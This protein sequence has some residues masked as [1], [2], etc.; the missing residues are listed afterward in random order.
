VLPSCC[1]LTWSF[2]AHKVHNYN[3]RKQ[4]PTYM[5]TVWKG[6]LN[7][8]QPSNQPTWQRPWLHKDIASVHI[9]ET[10]SLAVKE[11]W[12]RNC[13]PNKWLTLHQFDTNVDHGVKVTWCCYKLEQFLL[14]IW[15]ISS[16]PRELLWPL[17][18][19]GQAI[20][21]LPC[22]FFFLSFFLSIFFLAY[23]QP[24]Q[25]G[26][27]PYFHTWCGLSTC[28]FRMQVW[29]VLYAARW[30]TG[31]QKSP[32][33]RHLGTIAQLVGLYFRN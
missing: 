1:T 3:E 9:V 4:Q 23:S 25:I 2:H 26:C 21:F 31:R 5:A 14:A 17:Y 10:S 18:V 24:S 28:E 15:Q 29:N 30:N 8:N 32:K 19:I 6:T 11:Q 7:S 27:L 13:C 22:G 20:I 16:Q 33:I 12:R